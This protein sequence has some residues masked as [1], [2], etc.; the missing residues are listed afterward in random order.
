MRETIFKQCHECGESHALRPNGTFRRHRNLKNRVQP[1]GPFLAVGVRR[2]K[3]PVCLASYELPVG[4]P[5]S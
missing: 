2:G 1:W 3:A 4:E 5:G